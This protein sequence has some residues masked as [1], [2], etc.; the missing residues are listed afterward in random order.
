MWP[1]SKA[2]SSPRAAGDRPGLPWG[3]TTCLALGACCLESSFFL[4]FL[5]Q[6]PSCR[7][8]PGSTWRQL[9][10]CLPQMLGSVMFF[11]PSAA[12]WSVPLD[13]G[14]SSSLP[15]GGW[16]L[17]PWGVKSWGIGAAELAIW[18]SPQDQLCLFFIHKCHL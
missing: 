16:A 3:P 10:S 15:V 12:A 18:L 2:S 8:L 17:V 7:Q 13:A 5:L 11:S 14:M 6:L 9:G 1:F 4:L